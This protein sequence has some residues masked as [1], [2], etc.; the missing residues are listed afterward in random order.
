MCVFRPNFPYCKELRKINLLLT[1]NKLMQIFIY[2]HACLYTCILCM[3]I[4]INN[5][6]PQFPIWYNPH[7]IGSL[8]EAMAVIDPM[9][10]M[11]TRVCA[12]WNSINFIL[13]REIEMQY[14]RNS[15]T[16]ATG[17]VHLEMIGTYRW[18]SARKT[19]LQCVS[20]GVTSFLH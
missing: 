15:K 13:S 2:V 14:Q 11:F 19:L 4:S 8:S 17:E 6:C 10:I 9:Y 5:H 16:L 7:Y 20:T 12:G 3:Y 18:V 1:M